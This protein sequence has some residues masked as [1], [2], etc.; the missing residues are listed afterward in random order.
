VAKTRLHVSIVLALG[1]LVLGAVPA[2]GQSARA[3]VRASVT[4]LDQVSVTAASPLELRDTGAGGLVVDGTL[5]VT[6]PVPHVLVSTGP[7]GAS[8]GTEWFSGLRAG[9]RG[10]VPQRIRMQVARP[11]GDGPVRLTYTIAVI[12]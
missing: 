9:S 3:T 11:D 7:G 2:L 5:E 10:A 12:L 1:T 6:S 8:A 4:V